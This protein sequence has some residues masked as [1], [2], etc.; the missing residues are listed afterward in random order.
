METGTREKLM[1]L[2]KSFRNAMLVTQTTDKALRARPMAL[3]KIELTG[4]LWFITSF[5]SGKVH[6]IQDNP[7][8]NVSLQDDRKFLSITGRATIVRD[9]KKIDELW[10]E[11]A[12]VYF[13]KGKEDPHIALI[14]VIPSEGEY[15]DNEGING[16]KF[17][18]EA[19]KAYV[20]GTTPSVDKDQHGVVKMNGGQGGAAY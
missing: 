2:L 20:T 4:E 9:R 6:E 11:E 7:D 14:H 12:K 8:V 10:T 16:L 19:A 18:L 13:P 15:W 17:M 5:D 3:L 1:E